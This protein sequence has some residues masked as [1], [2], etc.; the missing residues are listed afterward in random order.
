VIPCAYRVGGETLC[1]ACFHR[2]Y[3]RGPDG[4]AY[5]QTGGAVGYV[6]TPHYPMAGVA[7]PACT[8]CGP[9]TGRC[10]TLRAPLFS[11]G[12]IG[13]TPGAVDV[14][15]AHQVNPAA[16]LDRH[17]AGDWGDVRDPEANAQAL[18][19][20]SRLLSVY[21]IAPGVIVWIITDGADERGRRYATTV[22][23]PQEY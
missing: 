4:R 13:A 14:L 3:T 21:T 6:V 7:A 19:E 5:T 2:R 12:F 18:R 23:L 20:G 15:A 11:L 16:L 22:M 17:T 10:R 9:E 1:P 8:R